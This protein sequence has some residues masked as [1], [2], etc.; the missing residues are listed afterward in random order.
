MAS[1]I[2]AGTAASAAR[3]SRSLNLET[4]LHI[5][6]AQAAYTPIIMPLPCSDRR[7]SHVE[8]DKIFG[9]ASNGT[10]FRPGDSGQCTMR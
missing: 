5:S 7:I 3:P 8:N 2:F 6:E 4:R 1:A 9:T 10:N